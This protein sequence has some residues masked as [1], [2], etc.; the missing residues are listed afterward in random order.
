M[1]VGFFTLKNDSLVRG[2]QE[3]LLET[4]AWDLKEPKDPAK[5]LKGYQG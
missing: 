4:S 5:I 3:L 1:R 2:Q